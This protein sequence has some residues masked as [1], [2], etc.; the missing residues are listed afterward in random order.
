MTTQCTSTG[1]YRRYF[2]CSVMIFI[3]VPSYWEPNLW[4]GDHPE[5][6]RLYW[7]GVPSQLRDS[8]QHETAWNGDHFKYTKLNRRLVLY[9]R[10]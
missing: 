8:Q 4:G 10:Y 2:L 1:K 7:A 5:V 3:G 9:N 6:V